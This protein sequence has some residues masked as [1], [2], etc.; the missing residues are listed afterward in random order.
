MNTLFELS[1][2]ESVAVKCGV[3]HDEILDHYNQSKEVEDARSIYY[4]L[5]FEHS[6]QHPTQVATMHGITL[7]RFQHY[8]TMAQ[9]NMIIYRKCEAWIYKIT[10]PKYGKDV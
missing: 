7:K 9:S 1:I 6:L 8:I 5:L 3:L 10:N 4:K 2:I